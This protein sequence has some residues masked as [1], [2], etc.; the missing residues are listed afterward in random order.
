MKASDFIANFL[1]KC[2]DYAFGVQGSSVV[3]IV[4]SIQKNKIT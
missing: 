1:A 3:H 2:S 4:D